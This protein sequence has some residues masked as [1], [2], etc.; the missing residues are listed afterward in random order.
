MRTNKLCFI[1]LCFLILQSCYNSTSPKEQSMDEAACYSELRIFG[2][3]SFQNDVFRGSFS[4]DNETFYFFKKVTPNQED[5]RIYQST[6]TDGKWPA[7]QRVNLGG[8]YSDLYPSIS[9]D[10]NRMVFSSYRPVPE[11]FQSDH[12]KNAHIWYVEKENDRWGAPV[13]MEQVNKIG[14]YHSWVEFGWDN[15]VF[16]RRVSPDWTSSETLYT[17]WDGEKYTTPK[18]FEEVEQWVNWSPNVQIAG[19]SPGP[20]KDLVFFDVATHNPE[21]DKRGSDIWISVKIDQKWTDPKPLD[22]NINQDGYDVFPFF[23]TDGACFYF[24]R[25]FDRFYN[26]SLNEVLPMQ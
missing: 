21:T 13:F 15:K 8:E 17:E 14:Y 23:S 5:Y 12:S 11:Q 26:I 4:P 18:V 22:K 24:V 20:T 25:G 7:P 2:D 10:G 9:K 16:F 1:F 3:S 19:G 6:K